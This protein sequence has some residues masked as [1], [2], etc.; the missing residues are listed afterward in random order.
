MY[1]VV[2]IGAGVSGC[3]IARELSRKKGSILV[4]ERDEDVC[5]GTTKA[6]SAI[7]HAGYD[8]AHGSGG[9]TCEESR[10]IGGMHN[11]D[12]NGDPC[13]DVCFTLQAG[14]TSSVKAI[15]RCPTQWRIP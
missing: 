12:R 9:N 2:I 1:D 7:V 5:C 3:A 15:F 6:N 13:D 4:V 10:Q 11:R 8:A 14:T